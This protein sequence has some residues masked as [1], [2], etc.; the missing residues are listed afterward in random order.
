MEVTRTPRRRGASAGVVVLAICAGW[1]GCSFKDT[2]L[3]WLGYR[4]AESSFEQA[5]ASIEAGATDEELR[6]AAER[7]RRLT[8]QAIRCLAELKR[9][10]SR[11]APAVDRIL[12]RIRADAVEAKN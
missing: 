6:A 11:L 1:A 5:L 7:V 4:A 8:R 2:V 3:A 9:G 10:N 12:D